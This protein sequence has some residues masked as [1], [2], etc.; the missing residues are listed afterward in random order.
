MMKKTILAATT[1]LALVASP[2]L[3]EEATNLL[4]LINEELAAEGADYRVTTL[5]FI[6]IGEGF[7]AG[8][9]IIATS[10]RGDKQLPPELGDWVPGD[11]R[12]GGRDDITYIQDGA[13]ITDD[14]SATAQAV[15]IDRA[16]NTWEAVNCSEIPLTDNGASGDLGLAQLLWAFFG[17]GFG[18]SPS[19]LA[20]INH[21]GFLPLS[22]FSFWGPQIPGESILAGTFTFAFIVPG[23]NPPVF[24]DI[25]SNGKVDVFFREI[26]YND[27]FNWG[28]DEDFDIETVALH[29]G[30]HALSQAHFGDIAINTQ[31]GKIR[32]SPRAVMNAT[33]SG[34][35]QELHGTDT[36]GHCAN[37]EVWPE[38]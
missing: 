8:Q 33:Y 38:D 25:D 5:E 32:F 17:G 10:D 27:A 22:F 26:Y 28:V 36:A 20:D 12:R 2:A 35:Q 16:M 3:A 14:V 4:D 37:W 9:T 29:E 19:I 13:D 15:A 18:G 24:T 31:T 11:P 21:A 7:Q 23:S 6:T 1:A 30:G 34:V